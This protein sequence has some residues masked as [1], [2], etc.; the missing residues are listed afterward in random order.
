MELT[1]DIFYQLID[2]IDS[3][4]TLQNYCL[5]N[6]Q[7]SELC[8]E[9]KS[10]VS[11]SL[12]KNLQVN[13]KDKSNFIY[14]YNKVKQEDYINDDDDKTLKYNL[15]LKLYM[16]SYYLKSIDCRNLNITSF[17]IYP[18]MTHFYGNGNKLKNF[19]I[20]PNMQFFYGE[21]NKLNNFLVQP[22]MKEFHGDNNYLFSFPAQPIMDFFTAKKNLFYVDYNMSAQ[23]IIKHVG[24]IFEVSK[25]IG[26][27]K[28]I[29]VF[30]PLLFAFNDLSYINNNL[31]SITKSKISE[32]LLD[33]KIKKETK[34]ILLKYEKEFSKINP[35]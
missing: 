18:N 2:K 3:I 10:Y 21:N 12:L 16:K 1:Y 30:E 5:S 11:K 7:I 22:K 28:I 19:P 29:T 35:V 34:I 31:L 33:K 32:F 8:N 4:E 27:N 25:E 15:I 14:I 23:N 20:Q 9:N 13:Y 6:K 17:P 24:K 26:T